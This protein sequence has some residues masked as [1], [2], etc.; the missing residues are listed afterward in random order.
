MELIQQKKHLSALQKDD[1]LLIDY[2]G[3]DSYVYNTNNDEFHRCIE[4][5]VLVNVKEKGVITDDFLYTL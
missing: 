3:H 5:L 1:E 4:V 2:S